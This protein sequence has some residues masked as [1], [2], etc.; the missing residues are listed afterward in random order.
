MGC[1]IVNCDLG[2]DSE[3]G[4]DEY[5]VMCGEEHFGGRVKRFHGGMVC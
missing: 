5:G 4:E 3:D 2:M 1:K